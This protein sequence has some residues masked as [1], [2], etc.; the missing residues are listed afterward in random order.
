[1]ASNTD[2]NDTIKSLTV[3]L[4]RLTSHHLDSF[5]R[6]ETEVRRISKERY[7]IILER[8][9]EASQ[10]LNIRDEVRFI[11]LFIRLLNA[12]GEGF[13]KIIFM[14]FSQQYADKIKF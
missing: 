2:I 7:K 11:K 14:E 1:M 13:I 6:F 3:K 10:I 4:D 12:V 9:K 5:D 8:T